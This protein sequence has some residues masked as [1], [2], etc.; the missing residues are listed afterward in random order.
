[1]WLKYNKI[2]VIKTQNTEIVV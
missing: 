2:T 1:M